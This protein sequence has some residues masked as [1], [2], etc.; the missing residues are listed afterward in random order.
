MLQISAAWQLF[1]ACAITLSE[2]LRAAG[3]T[4]IPMLLRLALAWVVFAPSAVIAVM[5][6]GGGEVAAMLCLVGYLAALAGLL[7]LRFRT[8]AWRRIDLTGGGEPALVE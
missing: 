8:G 2:I 4:L 6:L 5:V 1:D 7:A 3:D